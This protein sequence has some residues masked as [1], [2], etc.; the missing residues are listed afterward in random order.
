MSNQDK[1]MTKEEY[2]TLSKTLEQVMENINKSADTFVENI[3][4]SA[5]KYSIDTELLKDL[6]S[7]VKGR[8]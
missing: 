5:R 4:D 1:K 2:E 3:R 8:V 6:H 7:K